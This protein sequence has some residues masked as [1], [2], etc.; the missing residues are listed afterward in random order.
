MPLQHAGRLTRDHVPEAHPGVPASHGQEGAGGM[1]GD[2]RIRV[3]IAR[4]AREPI[5]RFPAGEIPDGDLVAASNAAI[6]SHGAERHRADDLIL[7]HQR[8]ARLPAGRRI[9]EA[10]RMVPGGRGHQGAVGAESDIIDV[11]FVPTQDAAPRRVEI[12]DAEGAVD[13]AE[14]GS[15]PR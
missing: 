2:P 14:T 5:S 6:R 15:P 8:G 11:E 12:P 9:P 13:H 3:P 7:V 1:E 4:G 10:D